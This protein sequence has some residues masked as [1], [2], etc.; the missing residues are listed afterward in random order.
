MATKAFPIDAI[1]SSLEQLR[2]QKCK[3]IVSFTLTSREQTLPN[4]KMSD[5]VEHP[6]SAIRNSRF[7][8][9]VHVSGARIWSMYLVHVSGACIWCMYLVHISAAYIWSMYLVQISGARIWCTYLVHVS[10][11]FI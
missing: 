11:A 10:G 1:T 2:L 6:S 9:L 8:Y 7:K 5:V 4:T 3:H